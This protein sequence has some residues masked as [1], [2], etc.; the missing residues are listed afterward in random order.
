MT[1]DRLNAGGLGSCLKPKVALAQDFLVNLAKLTSAVQGKVLKWALRFQ[2]DPTA[3]GINY[4]PIQNARE[5]SLKSVRI[6]QDWRGIVFKP[7]AGGIYVLMY[8]DHHD[9]AYRWAQDRRVA[10]NPVTGALQVFAVE[11]IIEPALEQARAAAEMAPDSL[12]IAVAK[13]RAASD[14]V[15]G[16]DQ[17][18]QR[19]GMAGAQALGGC[20]DGDGDGVYDLDD[21]CP[22]DKGDPT[23]GGCPAD[24]DGDGLH[25]GI[26]KCPDVAGPKE[27]QGCPEQRVVVTATNVSITDRIYFETGE[28]KI[29]K[30]SLSL[31][32]EIAG[33]LKKNM[34]IKKIRIEGHT[35][36][37][38]DPADNLK[39]SAD[40]ADAVRKHLI[41]RGVAAI[42]LEAQG[43]GDTKPLADNATEEGRA[44]N[45]RVEFVILETGG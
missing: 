39:L 29:K 18:R 2:C 31:I 11:T 14:N 21:K 12:Q 8:V 6:D 28:N 27:R 10:V 16:D 33:V 32:D 13:G 43:D 45:R 41:G 3:T 40:R 30:E 42:R 7:P 19:D 17:D 20:P 23:K 22:T 44:T 25:D 9:A 5:K 1:R 35:D 4:E 24:G 37:V 26:D 36:N 38:G 15:V 34:Q